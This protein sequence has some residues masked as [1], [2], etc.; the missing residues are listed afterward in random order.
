MTC[1]YS[2]KDI[3]SGNFPAFT[4]TSTFMNIF[5][6]NRNRLLELCNHPKAPVIRNGKRFV[7]KT[8]DMINFIEKQ[9][10]GA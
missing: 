7:I 3:E 8:A 9:S 1:K 2:A 6:I 4:G 10:I 5:P